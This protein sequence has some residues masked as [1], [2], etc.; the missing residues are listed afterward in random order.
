MKQAFSRM[1]LCNIQIGFL[2]VLVALL[3]GRL[4]RLY[5][6]HFDI[7]FT[8]WALE[9]EYIDIEEILDMIQV[10]AIAAVISC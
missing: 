3:V 10:Q 6:L 9:P 1:T 4:T 5:P 8:N 2:V 7:H